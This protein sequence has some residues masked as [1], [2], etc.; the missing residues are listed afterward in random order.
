MRQFICSITATNK[1]E[2]FNGFL[3]WLAFGG[4]GVISTN[5]RDEQRKLVKYNHLVANC[6]IFYN[7]FEISRILHELMQ[8][9]VKIEPET[10]AALSPYWTQHINRFG[11]YSLDMDRCPPPIDFGI[12]VVSQKS[13]KQ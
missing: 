8:E 9:G 7:V 13:S 12:P 5:N 11:R 2:S 4:E 10:I 3:K 1:S 6:L